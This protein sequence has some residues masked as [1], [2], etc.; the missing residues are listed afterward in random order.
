MN[1]QSRA[2]LEK[3]GHNVMVKDMIKEDDIMP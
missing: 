3:R 2:M 1:L